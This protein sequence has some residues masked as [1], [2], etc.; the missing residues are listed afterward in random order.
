M[1]SGIPPD[2]PFESRREDRALEGKLLSLYRVS[3]R[4][5]SLCRFSGHIPR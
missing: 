4:L 1:E 2:E 5:V 3:A